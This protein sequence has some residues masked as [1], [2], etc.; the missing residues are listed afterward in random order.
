M[1][2]FLILDVVFLGHAPSLSF[3]LKMHFRLFTTLL[4]FSLIW[5]TMVANISKCYSSYKSQPKVFKLSLNFFPMFLANYFWDFWNFEKWHVS[6]YLALLDYVSKAHEIKICPSVVRTSVAPINSETIARIFFQVIL[7][8][9]PGSHAQVR[10]NFLKII[11]CLF[12]VCVIFFLVAFIRIFFVF[13]NMGPNGSKNFKTLLLQSQWSISL[14]SWIFFPTF[15]TNYVWH[16]CKFAN[17]NFNDFCSFS[18]IWDPMG[19]K[20]SKLYCSCKSQPKV[21]NFIPKFC[22]QLYS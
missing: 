20:I 2:F 5:D 17:W 15:L 1:D 13:V 8:S 22:L 12:C 6:D 11:V 16:L 10:F 18:L 21:L 7:I 19:V 14:F 4:Q 3:Y 9:F